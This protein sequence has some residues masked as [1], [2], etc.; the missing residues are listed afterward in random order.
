MTH[1]IGVIR[2]SGINPVVCINSF[3]TDTKNEI[4][5]VRKYAEQAGA[6]CAVSEHCSTVGMVPWSWPMS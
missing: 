4:A 6:R 3:H 2:K 5:M 1:L